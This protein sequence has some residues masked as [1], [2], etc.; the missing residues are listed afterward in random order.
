MQLSKPGSKQYITC[1]GV[2]INAILFALVHA[3]DM[4]AAARRGLQ[5]SF[6][7]YNYFTWASKIVVRSL[8]FLQWAIIITLDSKVIRRFIVT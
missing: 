3:C 1:L 2:Y 7:G 4:F 8:A 6:T 5:V